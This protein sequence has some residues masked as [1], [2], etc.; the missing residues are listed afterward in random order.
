M[1]PNQV[2][3]WR[4][5]GTTSSTSFIDQEWDYNPYGGDF[6][7]P[8]RVRAKSQ[9]GLYSTYA[10]LTVGGED[11][12]KYGVKTLLY[13]MEQN[14]P[15]PFNPSTEITYSLADIGHVSLSIYDVLGKRIANLV[16]K[17]QQ[18]GRYTV[19]W[20]L[21]QRPERFVSSGVYFARLEITNDLG[22]VRFSKTTS[23]VIM[24]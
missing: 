4:L 12:H 20:N 7:I 17:S 3:D 18:A 13:S 16:E 6:H 2:S 11:T 9:D 10:H 1:D 21:A 22:I 24:K 14:F 19:V 8:Y 23:L 15:N 5:L